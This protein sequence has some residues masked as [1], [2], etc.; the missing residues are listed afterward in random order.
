M[1]PKGRPQDLA[2]AGAFV[3]TLVEV[4]KVYNLKIT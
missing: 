1:L 2:V 3:V 4:E